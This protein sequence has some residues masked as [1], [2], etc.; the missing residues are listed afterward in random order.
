MPS[1]GGLARSNQAPRYGT[2]PGQDPHPTGPPLPSNWSDQGFLF[3]APGPTVLSSLKHILFNNWINVL[4]VFV[5]LGVLAGLL[6]WGEV[7]IFT[8][9]F[10][11]LLPMAKLLGLATEELALRTNQTIGGL[12]NATFGNLV[13]LIV[14][15]LALKEGLIRVVQASLLGSILSNLLLVLGASFLAGGIYYP[16]QTFNVTAA[17]TASSLLAIAVAACVIPAAFAFTVNGDNAEQLLLDV[18]R[19]TAII[20]LIVYILYLTFQLYTHTE[21]YQDSEEDAEEAQLTLPVAIILL[22]TVTVLVSVCGE[23][24]VGSIEAVAKKGHL[25]DTFVGLILLPIVGN[26]A[27][28]VTAVTVAMKNKMDLTIG[29]AIGSSMQIALLVTPFCVIVGWILD[30]PMSLNFSA[31]ETSILFVSVYI[32]N[33]IINDGKT[34]WLEGAMLLGAYGIIGIAFYCLPG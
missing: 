19:G 10:F 7:M 22:L 16:N 21:F 6:N 17:Q 34:N 13:E 9:N 25:S 11:A 14:G 18:S 23:Y 33:S 12:L 4:L 26:A 27:E 8:F 28:H 20:L 31:F 2:L 32:T 5:P 24:L 30:Q 29:V 15:V 3:N 1:T